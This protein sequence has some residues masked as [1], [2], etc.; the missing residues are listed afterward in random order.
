[1]PI[2]GRS[3]A[4]AGAVSCVL[5]GSVVSAPRSL[6]LAASL[7][8]Q[9][10]PA[11]LSNSSQRVFATRSF[12][13]PAVSSGEP[14]LY[15]SN[16]GAGTINV[17]SQSGNDQKPIGQITGLLEPSGLAV[18]RHHNLWVYNGLATPATILGYHRG[19]IEPFASLKAVE[20]IGLAVDNTDTIYAASSNSNVIYIYPPRFTKPARHLT[21]HKMTLLF[22]V[23]VDRRGNVFCNGA[24]DRSSISTEYAV[25]EFPAGSSRVRM[26]QPD[27]GYWGGLSVAH[28]GTLVAQS[29]AQI[30]LFRPPYKGKPVASFTVDNAWPSGLALTKAATSIWLPATV[31]SQGLEAQQYDV[32]S[33][34]FVSATSSYELSDVGGIATDPPSN[35]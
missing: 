23:A 2:T 28:D 17:Y 34:T 35:L 1:M 29:G 8:K 5:L 18:D 12:M 27:L 10:K 19:Q 33:G 22:A 21:S 30:Y 7:I 9:A 31:P 14:L 4:T 24:W 15:V 32:P 16:S 11:V 25:E 26:L 20:G 6:V 13:S 3:L